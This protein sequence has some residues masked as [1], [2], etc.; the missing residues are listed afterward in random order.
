MKDRVMQTSI[1]FVKTGF[2]SATLF[3]FFLLSMTP[4][5]VL[6]Q[7]RFIDTPSATVVKYL[8]L[9]EEKLLF[10]VDIDNKG[11]ER[12]WISIEDEHGNVFYK[13]NFK[14]AKYTKTF[15]I[16]KDEIDGNNLRFVLY[17]GKVKQEQIFQISTNVRVVHDVVVAK[18]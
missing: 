4:Q 10:N 18:Q 2:F 12:C 16:G 3:A 7:E 1:K 15:G 14:D 8:G 9:V 17:K 11:E 13:Q 5:A 6:A